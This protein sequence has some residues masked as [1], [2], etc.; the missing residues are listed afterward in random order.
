MREQWEVLPGLDSGSLH[1]VHNHCCGQC[2]H[3]SE[4]IACRGAGK[5]TRLVSIFVCTLMPLIYTFSHISYFFPMVGQPLQIPPLLLRDLSKRNCRGGPQTKAVN[6]PS[7]THCGTKLNVY[8]L[9]Y[10]FFSPSVFRL[11]IQYRGKR[12]EKCPRA[13]CL[14]NL[15]NKRNLLFFKTATG[16]M[17]KVCSGCICMFNQKH[18]S[19]N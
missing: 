6:P 1:H 3:I 5:T 12:E 7:L 15:L 16:K 13:S 18:V 4:R 11:V 17:F 2:P 10:T 8:S 19:F 9:Y 14:A